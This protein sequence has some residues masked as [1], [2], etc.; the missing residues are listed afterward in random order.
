MV[1]LF[2]AHQVS[3][4]RLDVRGPP[5][6][7]ASAFLGFWVQRL[8]RIAPLRS[9]RPATFAVSSVIAAIEKCEATSRTSCRDM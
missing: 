8:R 5:L 7:R 1:R 9:A 6:W 2:R 4:L 3:Q